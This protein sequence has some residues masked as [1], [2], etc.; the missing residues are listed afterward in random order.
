MCIPPRQPIIGNSGTG[1]RA[2]CLPHFLNSSDALATRIRDCPVRLDITENL[3]AV[4]PNLRPPPV[5]GI[6]QI[7]DPLAILIRDYPG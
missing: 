6:V 2:E 5:A 4:I 3:L 1:Q 7:P